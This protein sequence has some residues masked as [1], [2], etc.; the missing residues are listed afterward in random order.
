MR[1][2]M[3]LGTGWLAGIRLIVF[4]YVKYVITPRGMRMI[5]RSGLL[6]LRS[7]ARTRRNSK[8][9]MAQEVPFKPIS[10]I[11]QLLMDSIDDLKISREYI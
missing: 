2:E 10:Q 9:N 3:Q 6:P 11:V 8:E 5:V 4:K 1:R 7:I